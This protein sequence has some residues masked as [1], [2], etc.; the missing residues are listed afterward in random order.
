MINSGNANICLKRQRWIW[1][2]REKH[3]FILGPVLT[4]IAVNGTKASLTIT[5]QCKET[6]ASLNIT[7]QCKDIVF[8]GHLLLT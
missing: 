3:V 6:E 5:C 7:C 8:V 2:N 1:T 4:I